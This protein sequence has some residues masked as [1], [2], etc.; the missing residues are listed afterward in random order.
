MLAFDTLELVIENDKFYLCQENC[1]SIGLI[2]TKSWHIS[3]LIR[4]QDKENVRIFNWLFHIDVTSQSK[5]ED[6]D[7]EEDQDEGE[8]EDL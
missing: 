7:E 2:K 5:D 1:R 3:P 8:D 4:L 6:E